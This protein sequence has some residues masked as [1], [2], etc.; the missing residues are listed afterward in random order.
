LEGDPY[1]TFPALLE[2]DRRTAQIFGENDCL[3]YLFYKAGGSDAADRPRY[4]LH[5]RDMRKLY[6][7]ALSYHA[8]T[9]LHA[10][11]RAGKKPSKIKSEKRRL[12]RHLSPEIYANRH[13]F[14][15]SREPEDMGILEKLGFEDDFTMG[16]ADVAGFRLGTA[17]PVY[18]INA[19]KRRLSSKLRLHPLT[20]MD[21]T[22]SESKYMGLTES[23]ALDYCA[24]LINESR[25]MNGEVTL[26]WHNTSV[27]DGT[28]YHKSLYAELLHLC[29]RG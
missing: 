3:I 17:R 7:L 21:S 16:Y 26:L 11:Y 4:N 29:E 8:G 19:A 27:V 5:G 20:V 2:A 25:R 23:E 15:A 1:Y 10:S 18:W 13:H 12:Q 6:N 24:G 9:G 14:L 28:G 22:L